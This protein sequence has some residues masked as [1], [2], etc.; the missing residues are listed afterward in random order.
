MSITSVFLGFVAGVLS[1]LS[2]CVLPLLPLVLGAAV[3]EHRWGPA[4]LAAGLAL[5]FVAIGLFVATIGFAL[6]L[7]TNVFRGVAALLLVAAGVV[8]VVPALQTRFASAGGPVSNW[9]DRRLS[10]FS[11]SGLS[12]QFAL[13]L[14]LGA[15]WSPC[16]GPTLG[17]ASLLASQGRDLFQVSAV[18]VAFGLGA[19]LPL[20]MIGSFSREWLAR[21]RDQMLKAGK[22]GKM[23]LG[24]LLLITGLFILTGAD[25]RLETYLVDRSPQWLLEL[26]SRI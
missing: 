20:L 19:A 11:T 15:I 2:P 6:G 18:M 22:S 5:S 21:R 16:V 12:G 7:D 13:G 24:G 25:K 10:G 8:L 9:A 14:L 3:S 26:S 1:I 4:V 23:V 17:A